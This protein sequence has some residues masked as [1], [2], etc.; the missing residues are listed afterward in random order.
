[1]NLITNT[2]L[3]CA[4]LVSGR[5]SDGIS[6][7]AHE[8]GHAM[9]AKALFKDANPVISV[10]SLIWGDGSCRYLPRNPT[11][12][13]SRFSQ[14]TRIGLISAAG[15]IV[16]YINITSSLIASWKCRNKCHPLAISLASHAFF[17]SMR[18]FNYCCMVEDKDI[19]HDYFSIA[20]NLSIPYAVLST[21]TGTATVISGTWLAYLASPLSITYGSQPSNNDRDRIEKAAYLKSLLKIN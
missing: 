16:D 8:W 5:L 2:M 4:G 7:Y 14:K 10:T 11:S 13:G 17:K 19:D 12:L 3:C 15:P 1:M 6:T 20:E 9:A 18:T 21:L